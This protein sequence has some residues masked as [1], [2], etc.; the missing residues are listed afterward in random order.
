M[1]LGR[2]GKGQL[3]GFF[4]PKNTWYATR[5]LTVALCLEV[6]PPHSEISAY[7]L[8]HQLQYLLPRAIRRHPRYLSI[9]C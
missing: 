7:G 5:Q 4:L 8:A 9:Q 1:Q 3:G 6:A 2:P